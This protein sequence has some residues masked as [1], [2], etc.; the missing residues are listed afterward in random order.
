MTLSRAHV[1]ALAIA[2]ML[3]LTTLTGCAAEPAARSRNDVSSPASY[4]AASCPAESAVSHAAAEEVVGPIP[5]KLTTVPAGS[6]VCSYYGEDS[7]SVTLA[8]GSTGPDGFEA[9]ASAADEFYSAAERLPTDDVHADDVRRLGTAA[10]MDLRSEYFVI[11][12]GEVVAVALLQLPRPSLTSDVAL[13]ELL[14]ADEKPD[15]SQEPLVVPTCANA[16][17]VGAALGQDVV[18]THRSDWRDFPLPS[19]TCDYETT[20]GRAIFISLSGSSGGEKAFAE[21]VAGTAASGLPTTTTTLDVGDEAV[22]VELHGENGDVAGHL[23]FVR[24]GRFV[25]GGFYSSTRIRP[26]DVATASLLLLQPVP[27]D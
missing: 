22:D 20:R 3:P 26:E 10:P 16:G 23:V 25:T 13:V 21:R 27:A 12:R 1:V 18:A 6:L 24:Q 15:A 8:V 17:P 7:R 14:I 11:R 5:N 2:T 4:A 19:A 9:V